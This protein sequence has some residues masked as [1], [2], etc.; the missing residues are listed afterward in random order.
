MYAILDIE[1]TGGKFNEEG[2]TEIA[3]YKFDGEKVVDQ[4]ISLVNPERPIQEFVVKLTGITN[5]MLRTAPKFYEV[6][7]RIVE[8]T[9]GCIVV[10]HNASFDYRILGTEFNRLGYKFERKTICTVELSQKLLPKQPSHSLG[11]LVRSLGIPVADRHRANGDAMATVALFKVLLAK[12]LQKEIVS[13]FVK[14]LNIK[15]NTKLH[16]IVSDLPT[17]TGVYYFY[18][19]AGDIIYIGKSNNIKKRV[20]QHFTSNANKAKA[21]QKDIDRVTF[22]ITG[23]EM[24]ALLLE[25]EEIKRHKPKYNKALK[26][27]IFTHALYPIT[28]DY[29]Y[30]HLKLLKA[31][32]RKKH[33]TT[34]SSKDSG[35]NFLRR[36]SEQHGLCEKYTGIYTGKGNCFKYDLKDCAGACKG[37]ES[38]EEYNTRIR[39]IID[40][41]SLREKNTLIIDRGRTV[42]EKSLVLIENS[43]FKGYAFFKL[44]HQISSRSIL[45]AILVPM[46]DNRDAQHIIQTQLR[47][48]RKLKFRE[49]PN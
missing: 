21:I 10:A 25:N 19:E 18:N 5:K 22:E 48:N 40:K 36:I 17:K 15:L 16:Q 9:E 45:D 47:K 38:Y 3:I 12:D 11:K 43:I 26:R 4:F 6:A 20:N 34:F 7:K 8:I 30:I 49:I 29:G 1:S 14:D 32:G 42:D 27:N 35:K 46:H 37:E 31:D 41:Y 24:I 23:S 33:I 2:I 39:E 44:N 13:T 28:D